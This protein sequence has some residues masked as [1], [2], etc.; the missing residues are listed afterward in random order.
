MQKIQH[1][2]RKLLLFPMDLCLRWVHEPSP[3]TDIEILCDRGAC[4]LSKRVENN[5]ADASATDS[6]RG[7]Q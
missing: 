6:D 3:S 7:E 2:S 4:W 1:F 5:T